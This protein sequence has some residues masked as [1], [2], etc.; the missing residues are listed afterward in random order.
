[1]ET[2][3]NVTFLCVERGCSFDPTTDEAEAALGHLDL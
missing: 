1:M 3:Q 2:A